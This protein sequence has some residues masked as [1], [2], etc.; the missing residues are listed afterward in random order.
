MRSGGIRPHDGEIDVGICDV[1]DE[2]RQDVQH[3]V[4]D[5]LN[6]LGVSEAG[7]L[8]RRD[9]RLAYLAACLGHL[10]NETAAS[11]LASFEWPRRLAAS[12]AESSLARLAP[13]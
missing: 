4:E 6:H 5:N 8:D 7:A 11:A 2:V 9:V 3:H 12:S 1:V 13:M 10:A